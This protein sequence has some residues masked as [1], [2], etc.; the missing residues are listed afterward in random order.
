MAILLMD[1]STP[2]DIKLSGRRVNFNTQNFL[3]VEG[4]ENGQK[5]NERVVAVDLGV[6]GVEMKKKELK[7]GEFLDIPVLKIFFRGFKSWIP[8]KN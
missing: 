2:N 6:E 1:F 5:N 4:A 3:A 7:L 8:N